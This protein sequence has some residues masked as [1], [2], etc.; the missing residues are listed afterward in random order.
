MPGG[1]RAR[2]NQTYSGK[3]IANATAFVVGLLVQLSLAY[4]AAP[5]ASAQQ[6]PN[7]FERV[8]PNGLQPI[9]ERARDASSALA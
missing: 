5:E 3:G 6:S 7:G 4:C 1:I 9:A 2:R 8:G